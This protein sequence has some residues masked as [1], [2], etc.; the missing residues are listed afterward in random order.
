MV[1]L[2]GVIFLDRN[3][4]L[5]LFVVSMKIKVKVHANSSQEKVLELDDGSFEVWLKEKAVDGKA[6]LMLIKG[7]KKFLGK[8]VEIV[9]GFASRKK[10][11]DVEN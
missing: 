11:V 1:R 10:V 2:W 6:N 9:S 4:N 8:E 5:C 7:L 3:I